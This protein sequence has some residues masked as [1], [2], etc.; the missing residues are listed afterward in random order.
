MK[1]VKY[2][3]YYD[4]FLYWDCDCEIEDEF[5]KW[6]PEIEWRGQYAGY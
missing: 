6:E 3:G 4:E 2:V 1:L 5:H